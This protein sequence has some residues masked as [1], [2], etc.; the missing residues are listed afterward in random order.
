LKDT[1]PSATITDVRSGIHTEKLTRI[2]NLGKVRVTA[3]D[4]V[5]FSVEE[6]EFVAVTA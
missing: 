3:L 2:Y 6:G 5:D 4:R 1:G